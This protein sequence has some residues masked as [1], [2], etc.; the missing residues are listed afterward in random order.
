ML[1]LSR[2]SGQWVEI[3]HEKSGD[4]IYVKLFDVESGCQRCGRGRASLAF[5]DPDRLFEINRPERLVR[6]TEERP[7]SGRRAASR[8]GAATDAYRPL[9]G[10]K[11]L[12]Y[13]RK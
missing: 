2:E 10:Q 1:V 13:D 11:E 9:P 4:T 6:K 8:H 12:P 5:D 7:P 3:I